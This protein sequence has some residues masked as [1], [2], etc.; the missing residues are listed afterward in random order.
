VLGGHERDR[1]GARLG[2][3]GGVLVAD[4]RNGDPMLPSVTDGSGSQA[5]RALVQTREE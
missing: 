3:V 2:P 5:G 1:S 4:G